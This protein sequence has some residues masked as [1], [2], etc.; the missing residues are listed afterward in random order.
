MSFRAGIVITQ[1]GSVITTARGGALGTANHVR[2]NSIINRDVEKCL[3]DIVNISA[4]HGRI[5]HFAKSL[6]ILGVITRK[7]KAAGRSEVSCSASNRL[8][9]TWR[10]NVTTA[11][12]DHADRIS[13]MATTLSRV[14]TLTL[15]SLSAACFGVIANTFYGNGEPLIASIAFSGIAFAFTFSLIRWLG[16]VFVRAG[17]KGRDMCKSRKVEM[18]VDPEEIAFAGGHY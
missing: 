16:P 18:Y 8:K 12:E 1:T 2:R 11:S 17:L 5:N 9:A 15:F 7:R 3:L 6:I 4:R 14:E 10:Q 13:I